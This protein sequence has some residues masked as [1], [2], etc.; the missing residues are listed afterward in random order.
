MRATAVAV[1]EE[2]EEKVRFHLLIGY[3]VSSALSLSLPR[4]PSL[5]CSPPF[6]FAYKSNEDIQMMMIIVYQVERHSYAFK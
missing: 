3:A 4:S 1:A 2:E 5:I 6:S